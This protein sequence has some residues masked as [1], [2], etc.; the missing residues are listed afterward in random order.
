MRPEGSGE[1]PAETVRVT[2][3]A[4]P[5]GSPAIRVRD[6]PGPLFTDEQSGICCRAGTGWMPAMSTV[7]PWPRPAVAAGSTCTD[8]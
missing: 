1:I 4:F 2:R 3:T 7:A 8:R 6:E 5:K